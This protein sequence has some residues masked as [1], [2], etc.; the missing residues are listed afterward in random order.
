ME[1]LLKETILRD[2]SDIEFEETLNFKEFL[3]VFYGASW[4]PK[5]KQV[6][7]AINE[8]LE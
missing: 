7:D 5:S 6:A 2:N 1:I 4:L 8:L 3:I